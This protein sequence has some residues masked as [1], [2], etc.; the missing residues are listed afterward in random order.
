MAHLGESHSQTELT[1]SIVNSGAI[2][3]MQ[4]YAQKVFYRGMTGPE[5]TTAVTTLQNG[6]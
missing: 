2:C 5:T 3:T 1:Q 6:P 4:P